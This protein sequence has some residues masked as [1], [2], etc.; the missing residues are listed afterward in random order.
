MLVSDTSGLYYKAIAIVHD[1]SKV[2]NMLETSL[3]D[4]A[5]VVI[6]NY[7][8]FTLQATVL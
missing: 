6:S 3:T 5:R 4:N 1:D 7:H 2:V 8:M